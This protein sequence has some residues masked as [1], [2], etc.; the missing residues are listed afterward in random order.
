MLE[1]Y[2]WIL[3]PQQNVLK[4]RSGNIEI[5]DIQQIISH[6]DGIAGEQ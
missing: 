4:Y 5:S 1:D 2:S 6:Q 3:S